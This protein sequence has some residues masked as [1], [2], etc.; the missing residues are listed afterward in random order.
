MSL[1]LLL[2][3]GL[4]AA[5]AVEPPLPALRVAPA[6]GGSLLYV[7][8]IAAKPLTACL[9]EIVDY[10]GS[11]FSHG[12]DTYADD[13]APDGIAPQEERRIQVGE[14][15]PGAVPDYV[16]VRAAIFADGSTAGPPAKVAELVNRRRILL[17]ITR[18][19]IVHIAEAAKKDAAIADLREWLDLA[20]RDRRPVILRALDSLARRDTVDDTLLFLRRRESAMVASKPPL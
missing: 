2:A 4:A 16:K 17:E 3:A 7:K 11:N 14:M 20:P 18:E 6:D 12:Y 8:N 15:L 10:P 1:R 9:V 13:D 19:L 5:A